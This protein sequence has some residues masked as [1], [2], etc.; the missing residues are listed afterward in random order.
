MAKEP[1][2]AKQRTFSYHWGNGI[3]AEEAR[4]EGEYHVPALQLLRY[5]EGEA[6]GGESIRFCY[7]NHRG[8]YQR[9]P[10]VLSEPEIAALRAALRQTPRLRELL[11]RLVD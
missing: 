2:P 6:T 5:T 11:R 10:L 4:V 7:Y 3:V 8:M 9:A 1:K